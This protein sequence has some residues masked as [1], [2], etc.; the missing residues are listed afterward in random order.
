MLTEFALVSMIGWKSLRLRT[1]PYL[2]YAL[3][4]PS[5]GRV[6]LYR[7]VTD[8]QAVPFQK[9]ELPTLSSIL[10]SYDRFLFALGGNTV[11][12]HMERNSLSTDATYS[13]AMA[14]ITLSE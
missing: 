8:R 4:T 12:E 14:D 11:Y 5:I 1:G 13:E 6:T 7:P 10:P 9:S 2:R 3:F